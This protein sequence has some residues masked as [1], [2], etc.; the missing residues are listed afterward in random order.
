MDGWVV[1]KFNYYYYDFVFI[2]LPCSKQ[3]TKKMYKRHH[4]TLNSEHRWQ[5]IYCRLCNLYMYSNIH[6][7]WIWSKRWNHKRIHFTTSSYK[8]FGHWNAFHLS[9]FPTKCDILHD[10]VHSQIIKLN[11]RKSKLVCITHQVCRPFS[12]NNY[13]PTEMPI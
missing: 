1:I 8:H 2:F 6:S 10:C 12:Q 13:A 3:K 4:T 7:H 9:H 5:Y 11:L